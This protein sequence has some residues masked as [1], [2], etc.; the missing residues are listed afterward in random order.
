MDGC[1]RVIAPRVSVAPLTV[2]P[3]AV[4]LM[5]V[6]VPPDVI[7]ADA[8]MLVAPAEV[9]F[10]AATLIDATPLLSVKAVPEVGVNVR[11]V[12]DA[13]VK[14]TTAPD[15]GV[16][17][18]S[19]SVAVAVIGDPYVTL[20]TVVDPLVKVNERNPWVVVVVLLPVEE[21]DV[22]LLPPQAIRQKS[23]IREI[24]SHNDRDNFVCIDF[25]ILLP[26]LKR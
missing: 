3:N 21:E 14:V 13:A 7:G 12:V 1:P 26:F 22:S 2:I 25:T 18:E 20:F 16:P 15:T 8:V 17:E 10:K 6:V 4:L 9:E 19:V 24:S 11:R 5:V 23:A